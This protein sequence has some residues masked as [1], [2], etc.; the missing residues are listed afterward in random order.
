MV[1]CFGNPVHRCGKRLAIKMTNSGVKDVHVV[2][3]DDFFNP[4]LWCDPKELNGRFVV[5]FLDVVH[6]GGLLNRLVTVCRQGDPGALTGVAI[7]D[8]SSGEVSDVPLVGLWAEQ[9]EKRDLCAESITGRERYFDP[10]AGRARL[11]QDLPSEVSDLD[12]A[13]ATIESRLIE[14]RPIARYIQATGAL[15]QDACI[16]GVSYPWALDLLCLLSNDEARAELSRRA[17]ICLSDLVERGPW[18]LVFPAVRHQRAGAWAELLADRFGW[19]IVKVGLKKHLHYRPLTSAQRSAVARH[20]RALIVDAAIRSGKTLQSLVSLLRP[21]GRPHNLEITAFYAIDG[22]FDE[23]R[24]VLKGSLGVEIRS[25]F[26]LP[27]GA[28]TES[29]GRYCRKWLNTTLGEL[30]TP[31]PSEQAPWA[32]VV[33]DYCRKKLENSGRPPKQRSPEELERVLRRALDEG[34]RGAQ[35]CLESSCD[36]PRS[37]VVKHLDV[38]YA[39]R[40][41]RT[42]NVLHGFMCN[43]M[44]ADFIESCALALATQQD[45]DWFDRDWLILHKRLLT[46]TSS[47]RWQFLACVSYWIRRHGNREQIE[48]VRSVVDEFRRSQSPTFVPMF[49]D[50]YVDKNGHDVLQ[51]RCRTLMSV[52]ATD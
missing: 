30:E 24:E 36:P 44:P 19:P 10:V 40:E 50:I 31:G 26:R 7:I 34:E 32:N 41:P 45:Y 21:D 2:M 42:R 14:L 4:K 51:S 22:L 29:V 12:K 3:A 15:R 18:C 23:S 35:A 33:L 13:R 28:P 38:T 48:R 5:V 6:S 25:L 46:N 17:A 49:E 39:L 11:G 20:P 52:L 47:Q 43:S 8:Q 9:K 16:G 27:L 37:S 1:V